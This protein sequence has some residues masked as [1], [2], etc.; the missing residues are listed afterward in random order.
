VRRQWQ[1]RLFKS[2]ERALAVHQIGCY[3][4]DLGIWLGSVLAKMVV[5][6]KP[7][8]RIVLTGAL[9]QHTQSYILGDEA[10]ATLGEQ[11]MPN[12]TKIRWTH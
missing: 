9:N 10:A 1:Q 2:W 8:G 12:L 3:K 6:R 11:V 4:S 5:F 7:W